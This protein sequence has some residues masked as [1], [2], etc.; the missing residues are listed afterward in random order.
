MATIGKTRAERF[1]LARDAAHLSQE[2]MAEAMRKIGEGSVSRSAIAGWESRPDTKQIEASN[3]LK[4]ARV[5]NVNPEWLEFGTGA[6]RPTPAKIEGLMPVP[7]NHRE[8]PILT[9]EQAGSFMKIKRTNLKTI[10]VDAEL[11]SILGPHAF[12][13]VVVGTSM[14]PIF[15]PGDHVIID[16]DTKPQPGEIVAAKMQNEDVATLK[17]YRPLGYKDRE[18]EVFE[19]VSL[20]D[21]WPSIKVDRNNPGHIIGTLVEHRCR[22]RLQPGNVDPQYIQK[23]NTCNSLLI[24]DKEPIG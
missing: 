20:N 23:R 24:L 8:L 11:A 7:A 10:W 12:A 3:L 15:N 22:R 6:M 2:K 19:L 1:K 13:M 16:P 9:Y 14:S 21:D 4:A 18:Q 5:L 17:K